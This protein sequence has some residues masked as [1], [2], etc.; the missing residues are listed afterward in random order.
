MYNKRNRQKKIIIDNGPFIL[1][2]VSQIAAKDAEIKRLLDE[3]AKQLETFLEKMLD[4]KL[5]PPPVSQAVPVWDGQSP[6][7]RRPRPS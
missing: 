1:F 2:V 5:N 6:I 4:P 7:K 3:L